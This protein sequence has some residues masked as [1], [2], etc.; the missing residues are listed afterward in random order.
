[1]RPTLV[2]LQAEVVHVVGREYQ[3]A[4]SLRRGAGGLWLGRREEAVV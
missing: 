3:K 2:L 1:V 4:E